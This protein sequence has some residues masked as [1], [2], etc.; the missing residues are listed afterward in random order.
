MNLADKIINNISF[1]DFSEFGIDELGLP[2]PYPINTDY[3][4]A[5]IIGSNKNIFRVGD[6]LFLDKKKIP[7]SSSYIKMLC[8]EPKIILWKNDDLQK[9]WKGVSG[10]IGSNYPIIWDKIIKYSPVYSRR[11]IEVVNNLIWDK[12]K[13]DFINKGEL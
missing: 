1:E 13:A 8:G 4:V 3:I 11:Y 9:K 6:D 10:F 7:M 5:R 12:E 2:V